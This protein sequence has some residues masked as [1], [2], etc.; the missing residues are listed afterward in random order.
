MAAPRRTA[1]RPSRQERP[2]VRP[3]PLTRR[4]PEAQQAPHVLGHS[5][6]LLEDLRTSPRSFYAAVEE[7]V[8]R[9][10]LP[11]VASSR[12]FWREGGP[13]T[14]QREYLRL[15]RGE[16]VLDIC[17]APYG[18]GFFVSWWLGERRTGMWPFL[19]EIPGVGALTRLL[20]RPHTHYAIDTALM[21]EEAVGAA[22][23]EVIE[24]LSESR[25]VRALSRA[26]RKPVLR[27]F[28]EAR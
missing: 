14:P 23:L 1:S 8:A 10:R 26:E 5:Y 19:A 12:V 7:A 21:F 18:A 6:R 17:A 15:R 13:F 20:F 4:T 11:G 9:R 27:R 24:A 28:F 16:L 22:I 3:L 25:G 2:E